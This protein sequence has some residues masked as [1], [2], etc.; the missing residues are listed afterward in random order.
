MFTSMFA[1]LQSIFFFTFAGAS[2]LLL[3][4]CY[5][6]LSISGIAQNLQHECVS[7]PKVN[8]HMLLKLIRKVFTQHVHTNSAFSLETLY[9]LSYA[10]DDDD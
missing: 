2:L 8:V 3:V 7:R 1:S 6:Q 9:R 10:K 5:S 4:H